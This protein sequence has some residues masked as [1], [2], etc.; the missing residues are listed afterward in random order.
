MRVEIRLLGY[1]DIIFEFSFVYIRVLRG[2]ER[3]VDFIVDKDRFTRGMSGN[4]IFIKIELYILKK[5]VELVY[6]K[7]LFYIYKYHQTLY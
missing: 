5:L 6:V 4:I 1:E 7:F 3:G 2:G